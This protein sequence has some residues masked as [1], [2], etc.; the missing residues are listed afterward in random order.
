M[1]SVNTT[2]GVGEAS[3]RSRVGQRAPAVGGG[4]GGGISAQSLDGSGL[5]LQHDTCRE[6]LGEVLAGSFILRV[7]RRPPR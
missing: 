4:G 7:R 6:R 5:L 3:A 1:H 2:G